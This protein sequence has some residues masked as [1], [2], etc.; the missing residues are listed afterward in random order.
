ML[1]SR[2]DAPFGVV[3]VA[4]LPTYKCGSKVNG[5]FGCFAES[6]ID[7]ASALILRNGDGGGEIQV[8]V[9][10]PHFFGDGLPDSTDKC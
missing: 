7:A 3:V 9:R 10:S 5:K 2:D 6:F 8:D 4:L 1:E